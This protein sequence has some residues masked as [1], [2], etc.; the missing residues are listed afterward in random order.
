MSNEH[1]GQTGE[2]VLIGHF[3]QCL[4][5]KACFIQITR[6]NQMVGQGGEIFKPDSTGGKPEHAGFVR[7]PECSSQNVQLIEIDDGK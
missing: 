5:C 6:K 3:F 4:T 7:C 1:T 2:R